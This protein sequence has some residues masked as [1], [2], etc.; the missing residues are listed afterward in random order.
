MCDIQATEIPTRRGWRGRRSGNSTTRRS[1]HS[2]HSPD[3]PTCLEEAQED[4]DKHEETA[5]GVGAKY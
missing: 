2:T 3:A 1:L 4:E 5:P